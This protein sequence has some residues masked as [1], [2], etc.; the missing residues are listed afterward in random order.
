MWYS[1]M[2]LVDAWEGHLM[3]QILILVGVVLCLSVPASAQGPAGA[4]TGVGPSPHSRSASERSKWQVNLGY[5]FNRN[6]LLGK[7]FNTNGLHFAPVAYFR[8][9]FRAEARRGGG[10]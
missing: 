3:R 4:G 5:Q 7:P 6:N 8:Q 10:S 2:D 9:R 1:D